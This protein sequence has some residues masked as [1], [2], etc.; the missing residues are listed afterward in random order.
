VGPQEGEKASRGGF[1]VPPQ[2]VAPEG[3]AEPRPESGTEVS[4][5]VEA[6]QAETAVEVPTPFAGETGVRPT[7]PGA[8]GGP[9]GAPSSQKKAAPR[10]R[11]VRDF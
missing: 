5:L 4:G 6:T 10:A 1:E 2:P 9:Q 7:A 3:L 11:Y 8:S